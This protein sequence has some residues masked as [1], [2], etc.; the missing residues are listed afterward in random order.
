MPVRALGEPDP[1]F[2]SLERDS[3]S[4]PR[5]PRSR[6]AGSLLRASLPRIFIRS[7]NSKLPLREELCAARTSARCAENCLSSGAAWL[8][9][10][11]RTGRKVLLG[12][13]L[14]VTLQ[15]CP[16]VGARAE[17]GVCE[18]VV[19]RT[20][21]SHSRRTSCD[22]RIRC[23]GCFPQCNELR[24][25]HFAG[26]LTSGRTHLHRLEEPSLL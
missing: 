1:G 16:V 13:L 5:G 18:G 12:L 22:D 4:R 26:T 19:Q 17:G 21:T 8:R 15:R 14:A 2:N 3:D 9:G 20:A 23:N 11:P 6:S 10:V 24:I 7:R 25:H